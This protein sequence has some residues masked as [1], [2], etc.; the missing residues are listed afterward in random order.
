M[1]EVYSWENISEEV[2][3]KEYDLYLEPNSSKASPYYN[4]DLVVN[5]KYNG[6]DSFL[7]GSSSTNKQGWSRDAEYYWKKMLEQHPNAFDRDNRFYIENF[8]KLKVSP[9]VNQQFIDYFG[10]EE[11]KPYMGQTL[12]HHHIGQDGQAVAIPQ[13]MHQGGETSAIHRIESEIGVTDNA[14]KHSN[15]IQEAFDAGFIQSGSDVWSG[16]D[17]ADE[18]GT[19]S[20]TKFEYIQ[21]LQDDKSL[22]NNFSEWDTYSGDNKKLFELKQLEYSTRDARKAIEAGTDTFDDFAKVSSN[23][24]FSQYLSRQGYLDDA[25]LSSKYAD[26]DSLTDAQKMQ[27]RYGDRVFKTMGIDDLNTVSTNKNLASY[28]ASVA[29][30]PSILNRTVI[31]VGDNGEIRNLDL[32]GKGY[33]LDDFPNSMS[34]SEY[35]SVRAISDER[36]KALDPNFDT[37]TTKEKLL[38]KMQIQKSD[39]VLSRLREIPVSDDE[40]ADY[41]RRANKTLDSITDTDRDLIRAEKLAKRVDDA[42]LG[43]LE[44]FSKLKKLNQTAKAAPGL[45]ELFTALDVVF[46]IRDTTT[47]FE[48]HGLDDAVLT[49]TEGA[50]KIVTDY[51][52]DALYGVIT[53][54]CPVVGFTLMA[55]D[56]ISGG[57]ITEFAENIVIGM[58]DIISGRVI[59]G[60]P[61]D[62]SNWSAL[63]GNSYAN[64]IYGLSG[65]DEIYGYEDDDALYGEDGDDT[66]YGGTG[67]DIIYG[68]ADYDSWNKEVNVDTDYAGNDNLYGDDGEDYIYGGGGDDEIGG[69]NDN[70][71][72]FGE[73]GIDTI[74]G[75]DGDDYIEGGTGND[76]IHGGAGNDMIYGG[77]RDENSEIGLS[78]NSISSGEDELYGDAGDDYIFGGNGND[79]IYGGDDNDYLFGEDGEDTIEGE[80]G[81]DYIEGGKD[82]DLIHGGKGDDIIYG[83]LRDADSEEGSS[84]NSIASGN[85][86]I[87]GDEGNDVIF[88]GDG[89]DIIDGGT[90]S[91]SGDTSKP[92]SADA[93]TIGDTIYGEGGSDT[94]HGGTGNDYIDGG[95]DKDYLYGDEGNDIIL[96]QEGDDVIEGGDGV[97]FIWGGNGDDIITGGEDTDYIYGG[98]GEDNINGGNGENYIFG[99]EGVDHI[100]GGND[101][102]YI[103]GGVG[104]DQLYGGNGNNTIYGREGNDT[105]YDGD[106]ASYIYGDEGDDTIRAGGGDDVIDGGTG[107]DFI[108]D[109]HG[110][111]IIIFNAG[112]GVDTIWD[113]AGY[114]TIQLSGLDIGSASFSRSGNDLTIS[115]GG[116]AII[117][118]QYYDFYN[119]NINGTDVSALINSLHGSENDDWMNVSNT[120]G[121][122]LY[123]EGGN[124][125]LSGNSGNDNLYGGSGNDYLYGNDGDDVLDGG[126][127]DDWLYG[128]NGNDTYVFGKSYGNDTI[129][130]WGGSSTVVFKDISSDD[131]TVS[132]LWDSTLEMTVNS[133][134][135]KLTINGYKWNQ[136]GFTFEFAD[137][138]TGTVNRDTWELELDSA[139]IQAEAVSETDDT[140]A[141][142]SVSEE[143]QLQASADQLSDL[144]EEDNFTL[145]EEMEN[146]VRLY[147]DD[148]SVVSDAEQEEPAADQTDLQV[149]ILTENMS[150]FAM[151]DNISDS[152]NIIDITVDTSVMNQFLVGTQVQ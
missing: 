70:D 50:A 77:I 17:N 49:F 92:E 99:E 115:F 69:G 75:D 61:W 29:D 133:T 89:D 118:K 112:Y 46:V 42:P 143:D 37:Y 134:G 107:N 63:R 128:G 7:Q 5:M 41:A 140:S 36:A 142:A 60:T 101:N 15:K 129:E 119:F 62:D 35:K 100:Y 1:S 152:M 114:N 78:D 28:L 136:G 81:N 40:I 96:G 31:T 21:E 74:S 103:D 97:N 73:D 120:N 64:I 57:K 91:T 8:S 141:I 9:R 12:I 98:T 130:D 19:K 123:G 43:L 117:L 51:G 52:M 121:D 122:L 54:A 38:S 84:D 20:A 66:I 4:K 55:L 53:A 105:I 137:G 47:A 110:N 113:A 25:A 39:D 2:L 72:L 145:P 90:D 59:P 116:D 16:L 76:I 125:N 131:M 27:A 80:S 148:V 44:D 11:Y 23:V 151:E 22:L 139:S 132:N 48:E 104:D 138:T 149:M 146:E 82:N 126:E 18:L 124:D 58:I 87:Y 26:Y 144:Y 135:D 56:F 102:D 94:I 24:D 86:E 14:E 3:Q 79:T 71:Y 65:N 95:S 67:S 6:V 111:D 32:S 33:S 108:Q 127:G 83:G 150:A 13:G 93:I 30:D 85:D 10:L 109:D 45:G 106:D 147:S 34:V 68:D 88:G